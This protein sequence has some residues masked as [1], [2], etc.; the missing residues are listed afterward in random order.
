MG[1]SLASQGVLSK[2]HDWEFLTNKLGMMC[3]APEGAFKA[4][5]VD[6]LHFWPIK[7]VK[8]HMGLDGN[9]E[10]FNPVPV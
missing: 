6:T 4:L 7:T 2:Y 8:V 9:P 5:R 1:T 3:L 10:K